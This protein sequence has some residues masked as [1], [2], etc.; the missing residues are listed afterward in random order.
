MESTFD[1]SLVSSMLSMRLT[2]NILFVLHNRCYCLFRVFLFSD[3]ATR[4]HSPLPSNRERES[5]NSQE[6]F[7]LPSRRRFHVYLET[8]FPISCR[9]RNAP[10]PHLDN[11]FNNLRESGGVEETF[12]ILNTLDEEGSNYVST[13]RSK[14]IASR[15]FNDD[16]ANWQLHRLIT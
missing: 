12:A 14:A 7:P 2:L 3:R 8:S 6:H 10:P 1:P 9:S 11:L 16:T 13:L 4:R 15:K 5:S